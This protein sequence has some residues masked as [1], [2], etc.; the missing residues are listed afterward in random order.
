YH[1]Y[2]LQ[3]DGQGGYMFSKLDPNRRIALMEEKQQIEQELAL[4]R[5][6]EARLG[7]LESQSV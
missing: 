1:N 3:Y 5:D 7:E 2:I 4:I 6:M